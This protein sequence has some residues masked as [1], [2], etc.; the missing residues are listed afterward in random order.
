MTA[1]KTRIPCI[2]CEVEPT[3]SQ[4][5]FT[6]PTHMSD[7]CRRCGGMLVDDHCMDM[8]FGINRRGCW[9]KR[10]IQCGDIIDETI[11]RNRYAPCQTLQEKE[12]GPAVGIVQ[13]C[14]ALPPHDWKGGR[15]YATL[16]HASP[17]I[18][19]FQTLRIVATIR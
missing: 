15:R 18:R 17:T 2:T 1:T 6:R 13:T 3:P 12:I 19:S 8:D 14:V 16:S 7:A 10:C 5:P 9:A 4:G 11:L